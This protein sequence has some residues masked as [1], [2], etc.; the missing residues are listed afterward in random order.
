MTTQIIATT[1]NANGIAMA[2]Y[3]VAVFQLSVSEK[4]KN[5]VLA[6]E[7]LKESINEVLEAIEVLK[8][9][10]LTFRDNTYKTSSSV[11]PNNVFDNKKNEWKMSGQKAVWSASFQTTNMDLVNDIYDELTSLELTEIYVAPPQFKVIKIEELQKS[12][13]EDAWLKIKDMFATEC[14]V[15]GMTAIDFE[16]VNWAPRYDNNE[17]AGP[18]RMMAAASPMSD[19]G[20]GGSR[21]GSSI[22]LNPGKSVINVTLS[23]DWAKK[24]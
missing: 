12:A 22:E 17:S 21:G 15:L 6:K 16:V 9:K 1:T 10:G 11:Q 20:G 18:R 24:V 13:L 8:G 2:D 3:D 23:V 19:M 5:A 14:R 4:G 7:A